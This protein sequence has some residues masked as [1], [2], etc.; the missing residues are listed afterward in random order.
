[1]IKPRAAAATIDAV[2]AMMVMRRQCAW[3]IESGEQWSGFGGEKV[4]QI[5]NLS[6]EF[7]LQAVVPSSTI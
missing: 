5:Y 3:T 2:K 7:A 1:V 4:P 6:K